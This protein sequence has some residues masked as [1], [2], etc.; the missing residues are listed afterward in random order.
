MKLGVAGYLP[1]WDQMDAAAARRVRQAG[2]RGATIFFSRPLEADPAAVRRLKRIL[3]E[4][5]LEAAQAN[6][7]YEVLVHPDDA[8]R[9]EGIRGVQA[10]CR[11][12][13]ALAAGS[14]YVRPGSLNP[15]GAWTPHPDNLSPRT[16]DRLVD[17]LRAACAV[18]EQEGIPLALEGHVVSPLDSPQRMRAVLDAV[19]SP[20]LKVNIDPV[21]FIGTVPDVYD[22]RPVLNALFDLLGKDIAAAHLKDCVLEDHLVVHITEVMPGDG[23]LDYNLLLNR[24]QQDCPRGYALIEHL[25]DEKVPRA[26]EN[27]L[28]MAQQAG[29]SLE[30]EP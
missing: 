24:M 7:W 12:G 11:L 13:A 26:R 25:P 4:E 3:T 1:A 29:V 16:F 10:L 5:G 30:C 2:F 22:T 23:T 15:R 19:G 18:A 28:R 20:A 6:G 9:A 27:V 21:N 8:V 17:S 14:V